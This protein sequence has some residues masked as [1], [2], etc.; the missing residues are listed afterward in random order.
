[1]VSSLM[2]RYDES[3]IKARVLWIAPQDSNQAELLAM[4]EGSES[5]FF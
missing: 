3:E 5:Y 2:E 4:E 1:M